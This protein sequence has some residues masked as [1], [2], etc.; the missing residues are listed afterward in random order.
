MSSPPFSSSSFRSFVVKFAMNRVW[1]TNERMSKNC[2][3]WILKSWRI[4]KVDLRSRGIPNAIFIFSIELKIFHNSHFFWIFYSA[5]SL[6]PVLFSVAAIVA[7]YFR[8][9][10]FS[11][12]LAHLV[13]SFSSDAIQSN[14]IENRFGSA[15]HL[16]AQRR[17]LKKNAE[18]LQFRLQES[19]HALKAKMLNQTGHWFSFFLFLSTM[20]I[21]FSFLFRLLMKLTKWKRVTQFGSSHWIWMQLHVQLRNVSTWFELEYKFK[22]KI[23]VPRA[24]SEKEENKLQC[25]FLFLRHS[26]VFMHVQFQSFCSFNFVTQCQNE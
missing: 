12:S 9:I 24:T 8:L 13:M 14:K 19:L 16:N 20:S 17:R 5:V 1:E 6:S 10:F 7:H 26:V 22:W 15:F 4:W 11:S 23:V 18:V 2:C 25:W 3:S 21:A